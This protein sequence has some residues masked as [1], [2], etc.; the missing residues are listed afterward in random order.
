MQSIKTI[1]II[2]VQEVIDRCL[3]IDIEYS[4][5]DLL[6]KGDTMDNGQITAITRYYDIICYKNSKDK[7]FTF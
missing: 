1:I 7:S 3:S 2:K 6:L 4:V 5:G